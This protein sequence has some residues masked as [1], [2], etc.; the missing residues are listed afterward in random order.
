[1]KTPLYILV[2]AIGF[3][4]ACSEDQEVPPIIP[5]NP[6]GTPFSFKAK[7]FSLNADQLNYSLYIFSHAAGSTEEYRLDSM[8]HPLLETSKLVFSNQK[9][10]EKDFR[11]LFIATPAAHPEIT[12]TQGNTAGDP[13]SGSSWS[14]IRIRTAAD[15]LTI[16]NYYG[17]TDLTGTE[18]LKIDT[19]QGK[20]SRLV[21][22]TVFDFTKIGNSLENPLPIND[23]TVNSIF[24]RIYQID[25]EYTGYTSALR[26]E[27]KD[28]LVPADTIFVPLHLFG[29]P[30]FEAGLK[31]T[32]PQGQIDTL[33]IGESYGGRLRGAYL[34]PTT[35][36]L[37]AKLTFYYYDTTPLCPDLVHKH[38]A[39]CYAK[40]SVKLNLSGKPA[41]TGIPVHENAYTVNRIGI[42]NNRIIDI[43]YGAD[44]DLDTQWQN[45][46]K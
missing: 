14:E 34:F 31:V 25:L 19:I 17:V 45:N 40:S 24:D 16:D 22:Q 8:I 21:G 26:L 5:E 27:G 39:D 15:S 6:T 13:A 10:S 3:L 18:L 44:M 42:R 1:M 2:I 32:I 46:V 30:Q 35:G 4:A 20:L 11:F 43:S 12:I 29:T 7:G 38:E 41:A 23:A 37:Q 28:Q 36:T 9:L 33:S